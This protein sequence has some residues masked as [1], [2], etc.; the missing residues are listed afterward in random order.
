MA[1]TKTNWQDLPNTTTPINSTNLNK[2]ENELEAL[3]TKTTNISYDNGN[4]NVDGTLSIDDTIIAKLN[5]VGDTI[6]SANAKSIY[7]RPNGHNIG[8]GQSYIDTNG[9]FHIGQIFGKVERY[10]TSEIEI[11]TWVD[12]KT[13]YRK[14]IPITL[15]NNSQTY[16]ATYISNANIVRIDGYA[17]SGGSVIPLVYNNLIYTGGTYAYTQDGGATLYIGCN[18]NGSSYTGYAILEYTKN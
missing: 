17:A 5:S 15:P 7:F 10:S 13:L 18:F 11:G 8:T 6:I 12:G 16:V 14:C 1:Y 2:I 3:D 4:T 9:D